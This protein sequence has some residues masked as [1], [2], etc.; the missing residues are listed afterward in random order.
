MA[1]ILETKD[2]SLNRAP[3]PKP[4][5]NNFVEDCQDSSD[6]SCLHIIISAHWFIST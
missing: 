1:D 4:L 6:N 5:E 2:L 3:L